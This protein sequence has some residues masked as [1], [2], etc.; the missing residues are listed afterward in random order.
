MLGKLAH[1]VIGNWRFVGCDR[2]MR[3]IPATDKMWWKKTAQRAK[4]DCCFLEPEG[5]NSARSSYRLL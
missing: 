1:N 3:S 5:A 2:G 4:P